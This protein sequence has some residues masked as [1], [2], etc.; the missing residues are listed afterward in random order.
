MEQKLSYHEAE[1]E[2]ISEKATI[3]NVD[4]HSDLVPKGFVINL[5]IF[6][7]VGAF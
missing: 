3:E 1:F 4:E 5:A 7:F 6:S 2:K